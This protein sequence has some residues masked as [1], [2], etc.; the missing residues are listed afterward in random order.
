MLG[1]GFLACAVSLSYSIM[2]QRI[3][4]ENGLGRFD[5]AKA[6]I[7]QRQVLAIFFSIKSAL[8]GSQAVVL[9]K[10]LS[11]LLIQALHPSPAYSNPLMS[12]QTYFI[13]LGFAAAATYWVT[14][15]NHGLRLFDAVYLIPM[16][17]I[18]WIIFSTVAGGIYYE[19]FIG[20]GMKEYAAY[21]VG[22]VSVLVGVAM[23]C[24]RDDVTSFNAADVIYEI[25]SDENTRMMSPRPIARFQ[26]DDMESGPSAENGVLQEYDGDYRT[27]RTDHRGYQFVQSEDVNVGDKRPSTQEMIDIA[28]SDS[29]AVNDRVQRLQEARREI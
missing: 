10:S 18:F 16:M 6:S 27:R 17:Q 4:R 23:L 19:E 20:F 8:F 5:I 24:P 11:M 26:L 21:A 15:L 28:P 12:Y 9:A 13:I 29:A 22:F 14:R 1:A 3:M 2:K 7:R 25:V